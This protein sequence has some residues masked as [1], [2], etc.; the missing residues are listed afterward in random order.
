MNINDQT[1]MVGFQ[2]IV[3]SRIINRNASHIC[4]SGEEFIFIFRKI[5][6]DSSVDAIPSCLLLFPEV[7]KFERSTMLK[8]ATTIQ[9]KPS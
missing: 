1:L 3:H 8:M 9:L 6:P 2:M 7:N 4:Q 5:S